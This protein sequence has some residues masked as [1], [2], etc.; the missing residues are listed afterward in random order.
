VV[1]LLQTHAA[2]VSDLAA[3]GMAAVHENMQGRHHN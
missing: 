1:K 2:E 3:R